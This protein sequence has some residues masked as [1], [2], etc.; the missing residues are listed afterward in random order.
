MSRPWR[1]ALVALIAVGA[2]TLAV[3]LYGVVRAQRGSADTS[4]LAA[5]Q[6][7]E[8]GAVQ[9]FDGGP[10]RPIEGTSLDGKRVKLADYAGQP[11]V[12]SFWASWCG[13]C[14]EEMPAL[15]AWARQH[16]EVAVV[17]VNYEDD[18]AAARAFAQAHGGTWPS[19]ADPDGRIGETFKVPGLPATFLLDRSGKVV[20]RILGEVTGPTL[21]AHLKAIGA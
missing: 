17:G 9:K 2:A 19:I 5:V 4:D 14:R 7:A 3:G 6:S 15:A 18:A 21:D 20:D 11:V 16:P 10:I 1:I 8:S 12:L 13:P